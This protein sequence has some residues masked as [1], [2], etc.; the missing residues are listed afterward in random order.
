MFIPL[1]T[2]ICTDCYGDCRTCF[3]KLFNNC[4][5]CVTGKFLSPE[6]VCVTDVNCPSNT[7]PNIGKYVD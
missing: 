2:R 5:S 6:M 7:F 4:D 1:E 3:G